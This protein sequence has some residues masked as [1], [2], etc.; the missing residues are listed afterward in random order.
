MAECCVA[1][2]AHTFVV[3]RLWHGKSRAIVPPS[4]RPYGSVADMSPSKM[5][6]PHTAWHID[7][8]AR[9]DRAET[10]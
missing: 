3:Y 8:Y 4:A 9:D 10:R 6:V 2:Q 1:V 5:V 7:R